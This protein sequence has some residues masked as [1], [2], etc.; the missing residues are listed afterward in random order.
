MGASQPINNNQNI[1]GMQLTCSKCNLIPKILNLDYNNYSIEYECPKHGMKTED[2]K[3]YF[4]S[5]K[6]YL[7][8]SNRNNNSENIN[9]ENQNQ[10][11]FYCTD[12]KTFYVK[13]VEKVMNMR[14]LYLKK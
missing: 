10:I 9:D 5:S 1:E 13:D 7:F 11:F 2:I 6:K 3:E 4:K 8:Q 14:S 12:C